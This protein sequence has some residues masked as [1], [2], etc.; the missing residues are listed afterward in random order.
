LGISND[1]QGILILEP[2]TPVGLPFADLSGKNDYLIDID[3]KSL[4][5]RPDLWGHYGIAREF[6]AILHKPLKALDFS[7]PQPDSESL[8]IQVKIE[9]PQLCRRY[10]AIAFDNI[11]ITESPE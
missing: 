3:N 5:H 10:S 7:I 2:S 9:E 8:K 1:D 4:T 11:K 6:S